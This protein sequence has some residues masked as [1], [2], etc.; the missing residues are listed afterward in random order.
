MK[1]TRHNTGYL[2]QDLI[3]NAQ[4]SKVAQSFRLHSP[5]P[6]SATCPATPP[7][8]PF[9]TA[10]FPQPFSSASPPC[11]TTLSHLDNS[12]T[13]PNIFHQLNHSRFGLYLQQQHRWFSGKI[14]RCHLFQINSASPGFDSRPMQTFKLLSFCWFVGLL[15]WWLWW[16]FFWLV[17]RF[18]KLGWR[19]CGASAW[20]E[21]GCLAKVEDIYFWLGRGG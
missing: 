12:W 6:D 20:E 15:V 11:V 10:F 7:D 17:W 2:Y 9:F 21:R 19:N 18:A 5:T 8:P 16:P 4:S 13:K 3:L 1:C 14:S